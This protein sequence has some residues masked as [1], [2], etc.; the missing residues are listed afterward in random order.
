MIAA[1]CRECGRL[2][3]ATTSHRA[4]PELAGPREAVYFC[5]EQGRHVIVRTGH[6]TE[7]VGALRRFRSRLVR[8]VGP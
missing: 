5:F 8:G 4:T 2:L 3:G 6:L 7:M 1:K